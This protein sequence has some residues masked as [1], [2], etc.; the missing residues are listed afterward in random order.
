ME[1]VGPYRSVR[2]RIVATTGW[3]AKYAGQECDATFYGEG[4][5]PHIDTQQLNPPM[6]RWQTANAEDL[7]VVGR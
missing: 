7:E 4:T 6:S 5:H 1:Y 2:V 3:L